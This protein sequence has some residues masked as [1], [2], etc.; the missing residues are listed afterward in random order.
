MVMNHIIKF[1]VTRNQ[2]E[3][4]KEMAE[5]NN[6]SVSNF[7]R[8]KILNSNYLLEKMIIEIHKE[9]VDNG[10]WRRFRNSGMGNKIK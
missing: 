10:K 4:I 3:K 1:A 2:E 8:Q 5:D 9:V 7:I 6:T